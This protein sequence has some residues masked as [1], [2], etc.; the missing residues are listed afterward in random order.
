MYVIEHK[1]G[2]NNK[3][4]FNCS[5]WSFWFDMCPHNMC[6]KP[7]TQCNWRF[8]IAALWLLVWVGA[9]RQKNAIYCTK[10]WYVGTGLLLDLYEQG[11]RLLRLVW[12]RMCMWRGAA[13]TKVEEMVTLRLCQALRSWGLCLVVADEL[14]GLLAVIIHIWG[15]IYLGVG[16]KSTL[17]SPQLLF[18]T[19]TPPAQPFPSCAQVLE[20]KCWNALTY[21]NASVTNL[22]YKI[23]SVN[24]WRTYVNSR[25][26]L[27]CTFVSI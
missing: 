6:D 13:L 15:Q 11:C 25:R 3:Y 16:G 12:T 18:N 20:E 26:K 21:P 23:R 4:M 22:L 7:V 27:I 9:F 19:D 2:V 1:V 10:A 8:L 5:V 14:P 17:V 24:Y